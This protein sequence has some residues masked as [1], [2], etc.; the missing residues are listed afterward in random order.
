[1]III[2]TAKDD[3][4]MT[5]FHK[6]DYSWR[7]TAEIKSLLDAGF[8]FPAL[9]DA[10]LLPDMFGYKYND[11]DDGKTE[12]ERHYKGW[13]KRH[14]CPYEHPIGDDVTN[15]N[16][17]NPNLCYK[18]RNYIVHGT[19][20][21][22]DGKDDINALFDNPQSKVGKQFDDVEF[23]LVSSICIK[24]NNGEICE[25]EFDSYGQ[26]FFSAVRRVE[27]NKLFVAVNAFT[28]CL[29]L[30]RAIDADYRNSTNDEK[31]LCDMNYLCNR[32]IIVR[33]IKRGISNENNES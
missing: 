1:M 25:G 10:I 5:T 30:I 28:L 31:K 9:T 33:D 18:I 22:S 4:C 23:Q 19:K 20:L 27:N 7:R 17:L 3:F 8:V 16:L 26:S 21:T 12:N 32:Q 15:Y 11:A 2:D 13:C 6:Y 29:E 24:R 14:F